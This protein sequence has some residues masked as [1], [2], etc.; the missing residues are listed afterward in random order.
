M[1][2]YY[3]PIGWNITGIM[4]KTKDKKS[5][6]GGMEAGEP[7]LEQLEESGTVVNAIDEGKSKLQ[8]LGVKRNKSESFVLKS[9]KYNN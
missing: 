9:S 3:L 5:V 1:F 7:L 4:S 6:V 2:E 8:S